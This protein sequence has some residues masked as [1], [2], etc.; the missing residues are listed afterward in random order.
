MQ[1][2]ALGQEVFDAVCR[3][4]EV[5][6]VE[7][8]GLLYETAAGLSAVSS[9]CAEAVCESTKC[10]TTQFAEGNLFLA[11]VI[12]IAIVTALI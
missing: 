7:Y 5:L 1:R 10:T 4:L 3:T 2:S 11:S 8:F 12:V 9:G 6:E